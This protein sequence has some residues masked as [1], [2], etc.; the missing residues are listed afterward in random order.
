MLKAMKNILSLVLVLSLS[1]SAPVLSAFENKQ[2]STETASLY[3]Q[4]LEIIQL[5]SET[6]RM[7]E[8]VE[9]LAGSD[10]IRSAVQGLAEGD[11]SSPKTVYAISFS[12][13]DLASIADDSGLEN[14]SDDLRSFFMKRVPGALISRINAMGGVEDLAAASVCTV[15]KTFAA[16]K[17]DQDVIYLY[18][19]E[20]A[21]PAAVIFTMGENG[22]V[23][24]S[25]VFITYDEFACDSA[26][27]VKN[28]FDGV[29]AEVAEV[30]P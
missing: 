17:S 10:E 18:T 21:A 30:Q 14:A 28:F 22:T 23:F 27:A 29:T 1:V 5:M 13:E 16:E 25:G 15:T 6:V 12:E 24:A 20:D 26:D 4:G 8:Y 3:T 19:Y 2:D 11:H 7:E 9:V